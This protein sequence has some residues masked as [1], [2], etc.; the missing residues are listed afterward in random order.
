MFLKIK[1]KINNKYFWPIFSASLWIFSFLFLI[2]IVIFKSLDAE[3]MSWFYD[4]EKN[5]W[6]L[7]EPVIDTNLWKYCDQDVKIWDSCWWWI[8]FYIWNDL[9]PDWEKNIL[10]SEK[11]DASD[12][13]SFLNRLEALSWV[14][15]MDYWYENTKFLMQQWSDAAKYCWEKEEN[16]F[17]DWYLP[18]ARELHRLWKNKESV[19]WFTNFRYWSSTQTEDDVNNAYSMYFEYMNI[20]KFNKREPLYVRCIRTAN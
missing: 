20:A 15:D 11:Q 14:S 1:D 8:V 9:W 7:D 2:I 12:K 10:I 6:D 19:S 5:N 16:W 3:N 4:Y 17:N 13:Y 18:S